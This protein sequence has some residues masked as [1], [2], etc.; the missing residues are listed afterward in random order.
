MIEYTTDPG[1]VDQ[2]TND[3]INE[4]SDT[5]EGYSLS[6]VLSATATIQFRAALMLSDE[7]R[8]EYLSDMM[9]VLR[10][11]AETLPEAKKHRPG[12]Q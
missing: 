6:Q 3:L 8:R 2:K 12:E 5:S 9:I 7:S 10:D 1:D 11:L 4:F